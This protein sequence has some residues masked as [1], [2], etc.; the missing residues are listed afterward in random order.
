[1]D[2]ATVQDL[3]DL[4]EFDP[5]TL[6]WTVLSHDRD[7]GS[8]PSPRC[9]MAMAAVGDAVF[10]FGGWNSTAGEARPTGA[11]GSW[12]SSHRGLERPRLK[13]LEMPC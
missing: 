8:R 9:A 6:E 1:M 13:A 5:H 2:A 7:R 12:Q 4:Y 11:R 10:V 3:D